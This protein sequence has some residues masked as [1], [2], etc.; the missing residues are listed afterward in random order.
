MSTTIQWTDI[1]LRLGLTVLAGFLIGF[2]RREHGKVAGMR[3]TILVGVAAAV[4]MIQVNLLPPMVG[5]PPDSFVTNDL[6][7]L[8]LGVLTGV[9]FIGGGV[10]LRRG[11]MVT[12]VTTAATLWLITVIGLCLGGGQL[13]LGIAATLL[14]L[15]VLWGLR[16]A[17][18]A[19]PTT[20]TANI[21]VE[22]NSTAPAE[23]EIRRKL[24]HAGLRIT[25]S[26]I[27]LADSG[28]VRVL[29]FAVDVR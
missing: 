23:D 20:H 14:G 1:T 7:R 18:A 17:K 25:A 13:G 19:L 11:D 2:D 28:R 5:K 27:S 15:L 9:G 22:L 21:T 10:I 8:P 24:Q 6:M 4:T 16:P 3:T 12:G 29:T 26:R